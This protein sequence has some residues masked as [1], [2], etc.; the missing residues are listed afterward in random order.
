[1]LPGK[2]VPPRRRFAIPRELAYAWFAVVS[3]YWLWSRRVR[4]S[5]I[6]LLSSA[7]RR[8]GSFSRRAFTRA[9][10]TACT[11]HPPTRPSSIHR[12]WPVASPRRRWS[13]RR[14]LPLLPGRRAGRRARSRR[15]QRRPHKRG[16]AA[17]R[18]PAPGDRRASRRPARRLCQARRG[19]RFRNHPRPGCR[20]GASLHRAGPGRAEGDR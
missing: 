11:T 15:P 17:I 1:M 13:R 8:P 20:V 18:R 19:A 12:P 4:S 16:R 10:G 7:R 2:S 6:W 3:A 5:V 14:L 9:A